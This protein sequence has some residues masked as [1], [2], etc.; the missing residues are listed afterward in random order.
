MVPSDP[1]QTHM[2][3]FKCMLTYKRTQTL[4]SAHRRMLAHTDRQDCACPTVYEVLHKKI[5]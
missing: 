5:M 3:L 4:T 1:W 2:A